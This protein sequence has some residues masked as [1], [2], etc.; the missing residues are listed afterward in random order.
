MAADVWSVGMVLFEMQCGIRLMDRILDLGDTQVQGASRRDS[1]TTKRI[2]G[3][4]RGCFAE[5]GTAGRYMQQHSCEELR[6]LAPTLAPV[7]DGIFR[8]PPEERLKAEHI[9]D[10]LA[11]FERLITQ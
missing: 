9:S 10:A 4:I 1:E 7:F 6:H 11:E 3:M 2:V 5:P 8:I